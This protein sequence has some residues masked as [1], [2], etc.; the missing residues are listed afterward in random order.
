MVRAIRYR[1]HADTHCALQI[2]LKRSTYFILK[3][4]VQYCILSIYH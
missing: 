2:E 1:I 4:V 3:T